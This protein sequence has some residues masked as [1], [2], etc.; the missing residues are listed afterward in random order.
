M[1][2][3]LWRPDRRRDKMHLSVGSIGC[4]DIMPL[5]VLK[6]TLGKGCNTPISV[7]PGL[8]GYNTPISVEGQTG[9]T[10]H[11]SVRIPNV[12]DGYNEPISV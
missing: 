12:R 9:H 3:S 1:Y 8:W 7:Q 4:V 6:V 11:L 2:I 5:S 10:L